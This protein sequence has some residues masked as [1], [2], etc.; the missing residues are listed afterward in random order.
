MMMFK[1]F[2]QNTLSIKKKLLFV[3]S[4]SVGFSFFLVLIL[5]NYL[6]YENEWSKL[7]TQLTIQTEIIANNSMLAIVFDDP[8]AAQEIIA[9]L[10]ADKTIIKARVMTTADSVFA[11]YETTETI[12]DNFIK[13]SFVYLSE[14]LNTEI[15]I[16]Q[17]IVYQ[18]DKVGR[19]EVTA[20]LYHL[21]RANLYY[22]L[23]AFVVS[24]IATLL[25]LFLSNILLNQVIEPIIKL[26]STARKVT[27][28]SNYTV[29]SEVLSKDEVGELTIS[30]NEMLDEI[31]RKD[32][33]LEKTVA[34]RTSELIQLN[35][36]LQFQAFHDPLT[37]LANRMLFDDRLQVVL[38]HAQR[39]GCKIALMY[40]D[41]DH[42]KAV[43]DTLGHDVGDEL[44]IAVTNR[45]KGIVRDDDTLC[46][47]GGDEFALILN[48]IESNADVEL[49]AQKMLTAFSESFFCNE[50]ELS[51]SSS[52]GI[53]L[54]PEHTQSKEQLKQFAD[55]AM[56]HSKR[57]GRN[58]YCFFM[59]QMQ[60][61]NVQKL[62][63][64]VLLKRQLKTAVDNAELQIYYQ[65]Q[66]NMQ[67]RIIGVEALLRWQNAE[68]K[69]I[70]PE[71]FI[72]LAEESGL[73][74]GLEEWAFLEVCQHYA[75]WS[76]AGLPKIK[77]SLNI[78]GYRLRQ[79]SFN[80]FIDQVLDNFS[81]SADFL[82]FEIAENEIMQNIKETATVLNQLHSKGIKISVDNFGTGYTSLSYLQQLPI[83]ELKIDAQFVRQL[84][85]HYEKTSVVQAITGLAQSL[86]KSV[87]AMGVEQQTQEQ[88]LQ[89]LH[90]H[91]MQGYLIAKPMT[92]ADIRLMLSNN[93][94]LM[95][96]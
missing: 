48:T 88:I 91:A 77:I 55:I 95:E 33:L 11:H 69:M 12:A 72:P 42:F 7:R 94:Y 89:D 60:K 39:V 30:F 27:H 18:G 1:S 92:E 49:V 85:N 84:S 5:F 9:A 34:E 38:T 87:V 76:S 25:T 63:S 78:S 75:K 29:R 47:L 52:M 56:Y 37:G 70:S 17:D 74:Q 58:N 62:D 16:Q 13:D 24:V 15:N 10:K 65:P 19:L 32:L 53:S 51:I 35:K 50:H 28:L 82:V 6:N 40:F 66:V 46:R 54:Y 3:T 4:L 57:S 96:K 44:L 61:E 21:Y 93:P 83:D 68:N 81:L 36:K 22:L 67:R 73:I 90:C 8:I 80:H 26:T 2:H 59:A 71:I 64:R 41:L 45:M 14:W 31:Q 86:N 43:N 23:V 79:K 20:S